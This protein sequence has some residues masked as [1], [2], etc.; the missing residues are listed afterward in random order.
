MKDVYDYLY[1]S[2]KYGGGPVKPLYD[3]CSSSMNVGSIADICCGQGI[4]N[5]YVPKTTPYHGYDFSESALEKCRKRFGFRDYSF[6]DMTSKSVEREPYDNVFMCDALEHFSEDQLPDVFSNVISFCK[7]NTKV[8]F[9]ISTRPSILW[10]VDGKKIQL[11]LT[12]QPAN[13]WLSYV[14]KYLTIVRHKVN[15]DTILIECVMK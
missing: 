12:V 7:T 4:L 5:L 13:W 1:K 3:W 15:S 2:G 14:E 10:D 8:F 6:I 9:S 11:H